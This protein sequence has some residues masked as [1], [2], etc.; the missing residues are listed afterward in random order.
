M[1][2]PK[3]SFQGQ[4]LL[5]LDSFQGTIV[6]FNTGCAKIKVGGAYNLIVC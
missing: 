1:E 2:T 6:T 4:L 3:D 5:T